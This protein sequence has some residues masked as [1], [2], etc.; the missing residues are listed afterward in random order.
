MNFD[1]HSNY[2]WIFIHFHYPKIEEE[3]INNKK[4]NLLFLAILLFLEYPCNSMHLLNIKLN[5]FQMNLNNGI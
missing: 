4:V 1:F 5:C 2:R 3:K